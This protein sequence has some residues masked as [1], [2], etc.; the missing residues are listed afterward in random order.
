MIGAEE[1]RRGGVWRAPVLW[2]IAVAAA[3]G[4]AVLLVLMIGASLRAGKAQDAAIERQLHTWQVMFTAE[5]LRSSMYDTQRGMRGFLIS[6][7]AEFLGPYAHARD[8]IPGTV[9]RLRTL[10]RDNAAQQARLDRLGELIA[11]QRLRMESNI[12]DA[13]GGRLSEV[14]AQVR[15]GA[16]EV[17]MNASR[18]TIDAVVGAEQGLLIARNAA[19]AAA[20]ADAA[21]ATRSLSVL[22]LLLLAVALVAGG[23]SIRAAL[24]A[25]RASDAAISAARAR[26]VLEVAV[27]QRTAEITLSNARLK[28]EIARSAAAEEQVRQMQKLESVGQLTGGIAHDFNNM[29]AIVIGSL[30]LARRRLDDPTGRVLKYIDN[31]MDGARRAAT[32]TAK[33]LAFSRQQALAPEP[34]DANVF[35]KAISEL[36]RRTLG[37]GVEIETVLAGGL[38]RTYADAGELENAVLNLA[39]NARDAMGGTG[40]LTIETNN[41]HLDDAY[42]ATHTDVTPGQYVVVCV[43]DTGGGMPQA[44]IDKAFDPF[45]TTKEVGKGTGLGLSQVYGFVKQSGGHVKIYSETGQGTTVKLYL[46]RWTGADAPERKALAVTELPRA[47]GDETILV[48]E[49]EESVR[50]VTT[51]ALRDLGYHVVH[52]ADGFE[53]LTAMDEQPRLD[54]LFTDIVMPGMTGRELADAAT[55]KRDGLKV[56]YT[57]GYTRNAVVH[58]GMLDAQVAF[59]PK[60]FSI[61][62]LAVKVRLVLD[63]GGINRPV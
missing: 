11:Q 57:T 61:E 24:Q 53:A 47:R 39:V 45:F 48:V 25:R 35:V 55:A 5:Q 34:I 15:S 2:A 37:E 63:G 50:L 56:L 26:D 59:L 8:R 40:R 46:P 30:D 43:T 32:L 16:G 31:A 4:F 58:N 38:W 49:D 60:P 22:G 19:L 13:R 52:A 44:V 18:A 29:L 51:D 41:T 9:A 33:L 12:A 54:L 10:T 17:N 21:L 28:D 6:R 23:V 36:L 27:A 14:L 1:L 42:A 3:A 7:D 20:N 62:A